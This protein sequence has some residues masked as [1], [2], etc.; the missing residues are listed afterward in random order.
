MTRDCQK[1]G[2]LF[3]FSTNGPNTVRYR[4]KQNFRQNVVL[5]FNDPGDYSSVIPGVRKKEPSKVY[6]RGMILLD[7]IY[8]FQ[9]AYAYREDRMSDY[10]KVVCE[11]LNAVCEFKAPDIPILPEIIRHEDLA[12]YAG[13]IRTIPVG[14]A[15][16]TLMPALMD[17]N[18]KFMYNISG[19]DVSSEPAFIKG[20]IYNLSIINNTEVIVMDVN[21]MF[22]DIE[23]ENVLYTSDKCI[24]AVNKLGELVKDNPDPEKNIIFVVMGINTL[25]GKMT[26]ETKKAFTDLIITSKQLG[27]IKYILIDTIDVIKSNAFETW[28]KGSAD[29]SEAIWIGNGISNQFTIKV[30]TSSRILR[31]EVEPGFGYLIKKGKAELIKFISDE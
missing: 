30:T 4:M 15:K 11:K 6:G 17:L 22:N 19:D 10:I 16:E 14:I 18:N 3:V 26:P 21:S 28:Y 13:S 24:D 2:I 1:Y 9:T 29:M 8:E 7:G 12:S 20:F 5:Q 23:Y 31:Q 25:L 27:N